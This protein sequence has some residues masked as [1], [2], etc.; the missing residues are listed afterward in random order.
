[1]T[2]LLKLFDFIPQELK[3]L[4]NYLQTIY[5]LIN[6]S[7]LGNYLSENIIPMT[8]DYPGQYYGRKAVTLRRRYGDSSNIPE[9]ILHL[10]PLL[11]P[12]HVSLNT[13]ETTIKMYYQFFNIFY[14]EV[15]KKKNLLQ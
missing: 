1:M 14:K 13:R 4:D 10:V 12:L 2:N 3:S 6:L 8:V 11:G 9:K 15:F 7:V 5:P